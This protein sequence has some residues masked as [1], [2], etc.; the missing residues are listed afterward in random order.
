MDTEEID[1]VVAREI[2]GCTQEQIDAWPFGV[3]AFSQ[4]RNRAG[5]IV[6]RI[7]AFDDVREIFE[8]HLTARLPRLHGGVAELLFLCGPREICEAALKA[9]SECGFAIRCGVPGSDCPQHGGEKAA[10][11]GSAPFPHKR[12]ARRGPSVSPMDAATTA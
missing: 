2:F 10:R 1:E 6:S 11:G 7:W 9:S 3:P 12:P 8:K 4:D 5:D